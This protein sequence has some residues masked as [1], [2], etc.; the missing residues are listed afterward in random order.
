MESRSE[1]TQRSVRL[2]RDLSKM[3]DQAIQLDRAVKIGWGRD[4]DEKPKKQE[5]GVMTHLPPKLKLRLLGD[6]G[7]LVGSANNGA[8]FEV[9]G[10]VGHMACAYHQDGKC[11][12]TKQA[13]DN[14]GLGMTGGTVI[15]RSDAGAAAGESMSGGLLVIRGKAGNRVGA[16]MND[17][18]IVLMSNAGEHIGECMTGGRIVVDGRIGSLGKGAKSRS[19]ET[20]ELVEINDLLSPHSFK[21]TMDA[22]VIETDPEGGTQILA[23]QKGS[24]GRFDGIRLCAHGNSLSASRMVTIDS[25]VKMPTASTGL[26]LRSPWIPILTKGPSKGG[27]GIDSQPCMTNTSPRS[28]DLVHISE[29]NYSTLREELSEAGG[30][31]IDLG[32]FPNLS[33]SVI[34]GLAVVASGFLPARAPVLLMDDVDHTERLLRMTAE[35][36]LAGAIVDV[37][38]L[39]SAPAIAALPTVGIVLSKQKVEM[40]VLL[41]I[42]WTPTAADILTVVA[43]GMHGIL[44]E[45]FIGEETPPTTVKKIATT[46]DADIQSREKEMRGWLQQ[47]GAVSLSELKRHHL[48]ANSYE[49]AAMSGLRLEGYRQPLPMW[50]RK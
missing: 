38:T 44:A 16:A 33:E 22:T 7:D 23:P 4:G 2:K 37:R 20:E 11:T 43:A 18:T 9:V 26:D 15:L 6:M 41:R 21:L 30:A 28:I 3:L 42:D 19:I 31:V 40:S 45:P 10:T 13:G 17:G 47:M 8:L 25:S 14:V 50:S 34:H 48:R 5:T 12:I 35:L 39:G 32:G 1:I 46:L 36:G 27:N 24:S 49:S 29:E